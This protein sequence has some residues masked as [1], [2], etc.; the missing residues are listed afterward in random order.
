MAHGLRTIFFGN[1]VVIAGVLVARMVKIDQGSFSLYLALP[2]LCVFPSR[3]CC[4][5][6]WAWTVSPSRGGAVLLGQV[7]SEFTATGS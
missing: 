1:F 6:Y 2:R 7:G 3:G 4:F 5:V